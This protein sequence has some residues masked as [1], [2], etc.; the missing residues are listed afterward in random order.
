MVGLIGQQS[1]QLLWP[2][3]FHEICFFSRYDAAPYALKTKKAV[4]YP[5]GLAVYWRKLNKTIRDQSVFRP[6][7]TGGLPL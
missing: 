1:I 3:T 4:A 6:T 5:A 7:F 2:R